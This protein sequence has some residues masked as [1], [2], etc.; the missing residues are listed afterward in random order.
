MSDSDQSANAK[1]RIF[2][3]D[4]HP[5]VR[6]G[7]ASLVAQESDIEICGSAE[8]VPKAIELLSSTQPDLVIVDI[9]LKS[10]HGLDLIVE[11]SRR[12]PQ[13]KM[14]AWSMY[15]EEVYAERVLRAGAAGYLNKQEPT[16]DVV[17]A[18]RT[19][20]N[21][22]VYLNPQLSRHLVKRLS[23]SGSA[24]SNGL[25][26]LSNRELQIFEMI[27]R[28]CTTQEIAG[29]L[30]LSPKTIETHRE[31]IKVKL[32]VKN[33]AELNRRAVLWSLSAG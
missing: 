32:D 11:I 9:S 29:R 13:V 18:I 10:S 26:Q 12:M 25:R 7:L 33:S 16:E 3:V 22:G 24:T 17:R 8:D 19:V 27:G 31:R 14:L 2:V 5:I 21:G 28:G 23:S 6:D 1:Y 15:D 20:L 4:D 30:N